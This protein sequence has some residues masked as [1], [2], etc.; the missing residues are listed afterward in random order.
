MSMLGDGSKRPVVVCGESRTKQS[1]RDQVNINTIIAR[2]RKTGMLSHVNENPGF[3]ADVSNYGSYQESLA[4]VKAAEDAFMGLSAAVRARFENDPQKMI[5]FLSDSKNQ[6]EAVALGLAKA[7]DP[8]VEKIQKVQMVDDDGK[9][10]KA[11]KSSRKGE[12]PV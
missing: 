1:F 3:Y 9:P 2:Y 10:V 12:E 7:K 4:I 5:E 8:V 11:P 6:D